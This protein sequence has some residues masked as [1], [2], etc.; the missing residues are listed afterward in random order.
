[1]SPDKKTAPITEPEPQTET[2]L[3]PIEETKTMKKFENNI[4]YAVY[5]VLILLGLGTGYVL[6]SKSTPAAGPNSTPEVVKTDKVVGSTDTKTFKDSAEGKIEK[7]GVDGEGT[8]KL[9]R[10]GGASQTVYL[11]S[12]VVDLDQFVGKNVKVW[13]ETFAA[14]KAGWLMDVG[15]VEIK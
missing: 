7:G 2:I 12:S 9:V 3:K 14:E 10:S 15:K 13:G 5:V 6:A 4:F 11:I 1:M 8:H